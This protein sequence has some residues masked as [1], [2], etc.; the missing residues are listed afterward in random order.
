[1]RFHGR[2]RVH[3]SVVVCAV[4]TC[5]VSPKSSLSGVTRATG[6]EQRK[7][8]AARLDAAAQIK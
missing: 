1:M 8:D 2:C 3:V 7:G 4:Y 5:G 6:K